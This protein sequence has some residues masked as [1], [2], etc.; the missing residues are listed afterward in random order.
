MAETSSSVDLH[1]NSSITINSEECKDNK[2]FCNLFE[3]DY[4][5]KFNDASF[6]ICNTITAFAEMIIDKEVK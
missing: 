2:E 3:I 6:D 5:E 4:N 1:V